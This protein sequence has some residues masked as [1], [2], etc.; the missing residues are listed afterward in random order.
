MYESAR[1]NTNGGDVCRAG[2]GRAT[3]PLGSDHPDTMAAAE[4]LA[5]AYLSQG[6]F[7]QSESLARETEAA[8]QTKEPDSWQRFWAESLVGAS[9]ARQ[10]KYAEAEPVLLGGYRGML[11][12]KNLLAAP[13]RRHLDAAHLWIIQT[14]EMWGKPD[15]G[16]E[17]KQQ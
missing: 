10:K 11:A 14:Y 2:P 4:D 15:E 5:L 13:D 6:K 12:R 3:A 7:T 9:L 17:W 16:A 1:P 8:E